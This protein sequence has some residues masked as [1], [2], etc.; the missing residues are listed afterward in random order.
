[1]DEKVN[2]TINSTF[3]DSKDKKC[4]KNSVCEAHSDKYITKIEYN[5][6]Y[7]ILEEKCDYLES[8]DITDDNQNGNNND[9]DKKL[10]HCK[11]TLC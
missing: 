2:N 3:K 8:L 1:M 11:K 9:D 5:T 10:P 6:E 4:D 7:D